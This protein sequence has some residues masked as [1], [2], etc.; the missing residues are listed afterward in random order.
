MTN[1]G[2]KLEVQQTGPQGR[3]LIATPVRAWTAVAIKQKRRRCDSD[4]APQSTVGPA[5]LDQSNCLFHALTG[6]AINFRP[7]GPLCCTSELIQHGK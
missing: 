1:C 6:V 7:F 3:Q 4:L 2:F 5:D